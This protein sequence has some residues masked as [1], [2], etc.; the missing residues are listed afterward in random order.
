MLTIAITAACYPI[1]SP[2]HLWCN[3]LNQNCIFLARMLEEMGHYVYVIHNDLEKLR[4]SQGVPPNLELLHTDDLTKVHFQVIITLGH[5]LKPAIMERYT[6]MYPNTKHILYVCGN[7]FINTIENTLFTEKSTAL[8][9]YKY[10]QIW[11]IP[12]MEKTSVDYL[13]FYYNNSKVTVVPFVWSPTIGEEFIR[14]S[15]SKEYENQPIKSIAVLEPN[16]SVAKHFLF[17]L[18][19]AEEFL[20]QGNDFKYLYLMCADKYRNHP[21]VKDILKQTELSK[22]KKVSAENRYPTLTTL[23]RWA[24][25]VLSFQWENPLNYLYLDVAW[26]GWPIVHNAD[27]CQD[28]GYFYH[29]FDAQ[30]A[31]AAVKYAFEHHASDTG[32]KERM[33]QRIRRYTLE[34]PQLLQDYHRLFADLMDG[35]FRR[36]TYQWRT[37]SISG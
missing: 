6:E 26:W 16:I 23:N 2:N 29:E 20:R 3:G 30:E 5:T 36:W 18:I 9:K 17:P 31:T 8:P 11:V 19:V 1:K 13:R 4:T 24:D 27:Y 33:R 10:D 34:N 22:H 35:K 12:Q 7:T 25:L 32:Y 37:N 14:R 21:N 15:G 28:I